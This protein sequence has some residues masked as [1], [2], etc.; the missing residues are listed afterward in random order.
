[1]DPEVAWVPAAT[2]A[3]RR[4]VRERKIDVVLTTSPPASVHLVGAALRRREEVRWVADLR[5]SWLANPHRRYERRSV[6]AKR[7]VEA[8]IA[9]AALRRVAAVSAVTPAIAEE[10]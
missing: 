9:R 5:D 8:R 10:A 7:A 6:R 2:R 1:P 4:I 3:A